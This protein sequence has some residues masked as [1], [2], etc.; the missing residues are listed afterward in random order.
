M[1]DPAL[2]D[3]AQDYALKYLHDEGVFELGIVLKGGTSLRKLRAGNAGRFSTD[4]DF[5]T[6]DLDTAELLLDTLDGAELFD[7]RFT[8]EQREATRA[9]LAV[10]TPLGR[11]TIPAIV[12]ISPRGLWL[13]TE[14][15]TPVELPV[16]TGYEFTPPAIPAP[17]LAEALSEKLAAWRRRRKLRDLYDLDLFGRGGLNE[18]LIRRLLVLKVWHD[19]VNDGL[20]ARPFDPAEI[21]ADTDA[22]SLL[23]ED[24][25]LLTRPVEPEVW[26]A[27]VCARYAFVKALDEVE[28]RVA[29]CNPGDRYEVSQ[30][31]LALT[32]K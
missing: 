4:L 1:A 23:P 13:P 22:R 30:L 16:H 27:N 21:V 2:L 32:E 20:G 5:A 24:I 26:L 28:R 12:E 10:D 25:G 19:V 29:K 7:V 14:L 11:P 8:L 31:V 6:P 18:V 15:T 17:A 9:K 3:V